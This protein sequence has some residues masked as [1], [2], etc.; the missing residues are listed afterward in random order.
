MRDYEKPKKVIRSDKWDMEDWGEIIREDKMFSTAD[1]KLT[2]FTPTGHEAM[3]DQFMALFKARPELLSEDE[4][5]PS[6]LINQVVMDEAMGCPEYRDLRRHS[7]TDLVASAISATTMEPTLEIIFDRLKA[8]QEKAQAIEEMLQGMAQNEQEQKSVED[9]IREALAEDED[10][11]DLEDQQSDLQAQMAAMEQQMAE[12]KEELLNDLEQ[13]R[14]EIG[15]QMATAMAKAASEAE[16]VAEFGKSWGLD[17]GS[18]RS[19]DPTKR[20]ELAKLLNTP[21]FKKM[22]ELIGRI[23]NVA[24]LEQRQKSQTARHEV[25]DLEQGNDLAQVIPE[26]YMYLTDPDLDPVFFSRYYDRGLLQ[27]KLRG[28]EK[29]NKGAII[30]CEDGSGSMFGSPEIWAKAVGLALLYVA[31]SQ[32]RDFYAIHF[33]GPGV[34]KTFDF[35]NKTRIVKTVTYGYGGRGEEKEFPDV[36]GIIDFASTSMMGGTCFETP[37][38]VALAKLADQFRVTGSTDGDIVFVTDGECGVNQSFLDNIAKEKERLGF[39][40]FGMLMGGLTPRAPLTT[41]SDGDVLTIK[42]LVDADEIRKVF[43]DI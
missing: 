40:I 21:K 6:Y 42:S 2:N 34:Y 4:I 32:N 3:I 15:G 29:K 10:T 12:M 25:H 33:C 37:L 14:P 43:R 8:E 19:M 13:A 35:S 22:A 1:D 7:V 31:R 18:I 26:E 39:R 17:P 36:E 24:I 41:F 27:F 5:R 9:M 23:R 28:F 30:F 38:K 16:G 20:V 11:G